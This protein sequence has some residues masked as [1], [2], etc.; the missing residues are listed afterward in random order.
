M[1]KGSLTL[2]AQLSDLAGTSP[3]R[4]ISS[5][6]YTIFTLAALQP[7]G[8]SWIHSSLRELEEQTPTSLNSFLFLILLQPYVSFSQFCL[9]GE[10]NLAGRQREADRQHRDRP[11]LPQL[12]GRG[13]EKVH[14]ELEGQP[15]YGK[16][17]HTSS[18]SLHTTYN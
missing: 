17:K 2:T 15:S 18:T 8:L 12:L 13:G 4:H 7:W 5:Q 10:V 14:P 9:T 1:T 6:A 16:S 3:H 11:A